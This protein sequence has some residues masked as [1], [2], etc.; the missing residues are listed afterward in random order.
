MQTILCEGQQIKENAVNKRQAGKNSSPRKALLSIVKIGLSA[1]VILALLLFVFQ[2]K[3][4]FFPTTEIGVTPASNDWDFK[5]F[6]L[7]IDTFETYGWFIPAQAETSRTI[8]FSHGNA[9]NIGDRLDTIRIFRDLGFNTAIYDYGGYGKSTGSSS[10]KRCY[11][12]ARAVWSYLTEER[13]IAASSIVLFGR[14]LGGGVTAQLATEVDAAAV[15]L[16]STFFSVPRLAQEL[17]PVYPTK[18]LVRHRFDSGSKVANIE[19][20]ILHIHSPEDELIPHSPGQALFNA[21]TEPKEYLELRGGHND[22]FWIS[23]ETYSRGLASF[24][25]KYLKTL[26]AE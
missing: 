14:S 13:G 19:E 2:K 1:Y 17:Y 24:F 5:E 25:G 8:L 7:S 20:P 10:E 11:A 18:L 16:E 22:G 3:L 12:D 4:I 6:T 15:V 23:G 9:G 26:P 21:S